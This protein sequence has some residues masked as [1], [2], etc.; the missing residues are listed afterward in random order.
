MNNAITHLSYSRISELEHSPFAL[1]D[2]LE[3][4]FN[5]TKAMDEGSLL[6]CLLFEPEK[7][8]E[9]FLFIPKVSKA[10]KEG[11]ALFEAATEAANGRVIVTDDQLSAQKAIEARIRANQ[12]LIHY[13]LL[14]PY[15]G[16]GIGFQYQTKT[17]FF[18]GGFKHIG[19]RD[20]DGW[21]RNGNRVI[22]DLKK[23]SSRSGEHLVRSQI[24]TMGYD[25]QAAI[26]CHEFDSVNDPVKYYIIATDNDGCV[27]P[28]EISRDGREKAR[29][30]WNKVIKAAHQINMQPDLLDCGCEFWAGSTGFFTF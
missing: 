25:L 13:G 4:T 15:D 3:K 21:D 17:E 20:A 6:D 22:W 23:M 26:Y 7:L 29:I 18:Y 12:T 8:Q 30:R 1:K 28:F 11:K 2:Y 9:R 5:R 27:T 19:Y 10:T 24:R 16:Q 14:A